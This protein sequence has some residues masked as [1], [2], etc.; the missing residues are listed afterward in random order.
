MKQTDTAEPRI[1]E[2]EKMMKRTSKLALFAGAAL[3]LALAGGAVN[4]SPEGGCGTDFGF[5]MGPGYRMG[6]GI[7]HMGYGMGPGAH[8]GSGMGPGGR[9]GYGAGLNGVLHGFPDAVGERLDVLR[10]ALG[11][12]D[13]QQGAWKD[14]ADSAKKQAENRLALFDKMHRSPTPRATPDWLA[15][16]NEAMKQQQ[17]RSESVAAAVKKLYEV[18]TPEQRSVLDGSPIAQARRYGP[19]GR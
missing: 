12:T 17:A 18:L 11:I 2:Q 9:M 14:F 1:H 15:Q 7:G 8:M 5:G 13:S 6:Q 16:R 4:A 10:S 19:P 3:S